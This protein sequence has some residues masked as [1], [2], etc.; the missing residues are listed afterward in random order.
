MSK[1]LI[2]L[3]RHGSLLRDN[4]GAIEFWR[5]RSSSGSFCVL[6]SLV[7]RKVEERHGRRR[8]QEKIS[9]LC[10]FFRRNSVP[11]S[12][13]RS[14]RTQSYWS[15]ITGQCRYSGR[16]LHVTF[17]CRMCNQFTFHHQFRSD[18]GRTK[19]EQQTDSI[20]LLVDPMD[21][22]YKDPDTIDTGA[23]RLAQH[24]H[25]AGKK[26]Q[27]TVYWVDIN[28]ALKKGLKF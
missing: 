8:T 16:F 22:E 6:S 19:F 1:K 23:P 26:H 21:N 2:Y 28:L 10:W 18:T 25:K 7:W 13:P 4:D 20:F 12:S 14:F 15:F 9:V 11:P 27:N 5:I 3:L 17:S 24:M